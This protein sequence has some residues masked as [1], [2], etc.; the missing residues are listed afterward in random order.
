M[1]SDISDN[2]HLLAMQSMVYDGQ[3]MEEM[4]EHFKKLGNDA[5]RM[6]PATPISNMNALLMYSKA[7]E[8]ECTDKALNSQL[9]SNRAAVRLDT[10]NAK[11]SYRAAKAADGQGLTTQA[12]AF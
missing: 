9:Y 12:I 3:T 4:A 1:P 7:L 5:F 6:S 8:M 10:K 11:A 2:P